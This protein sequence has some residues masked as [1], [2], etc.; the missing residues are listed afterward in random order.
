[1]NTSEIKFELQQQCTE[2]ISARLDSIQKTIK[3]LEASLK[4]E[5]KC[6][7]GDKHHTGRAMLQIEREKAGNQLREIEKVMRQLDK[8]NV[9]NS[10]DVARLGSIIETNQAIFFMSISVGK[11]E[12]NETIYL[13]VAPNSPIGQNLLGKKKGEQFN[14]NGLVYKLLGVN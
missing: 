8:V 1:M 10:S 5:T 2:L 9:E 12:I 14:F 11:L 3:D 7:S 4:D 13:G 6:T